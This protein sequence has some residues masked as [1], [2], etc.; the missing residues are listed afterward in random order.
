MYKKVINSLFILTLIGAGCT[1]SHSQP[2]T[3]ED[4]SLHQ[5]NNSSSPSHEHNW[6]TTT[7]VTPPEERVQVL[8]VAGREKSSYQMTLKF[9]LGDSK[10]SPL[11]SE[12][13]KVVHEQ[14]LHLIIVDKYLR[15]FEHVHPE[16]QN[17]SWT[18][19]FTPPHDGEYRLY[20]DIAPEHE[21]AIV[22]KHR[23]TIDRGRARETKKTFPKVSGE[24]IMVEGY[25]VKLLPANNF[26][27][28][29]FEITKNGQPVRA[30]EPYLGAYGHLVI[31]D[32]TAARNFIH[33]HPEDQRLDRGLVQFNTA[34]SQGGRYSAFAQFKI[35]NKIIV[36]P[37]TFDVPAKPSPLNHQELEMNHS[38]H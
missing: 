33:A 9:N 4:H 22:L 38:H 20:F 23:L 26:Q 28:L 3:P 15:Y 6:K 35:Q 37:F 14:K 21:E 1:S 11:T 5:Q 7:S 32:H 16:Y 8:S 30:I 13:L 31:I 36:F 18:V 19:E 17:N 24:A 27:F 34:F 2:S 25:M 10:G 12:N 29:M